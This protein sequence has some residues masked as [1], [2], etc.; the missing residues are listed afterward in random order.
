MF[1]KHLNSVTPKKERWQSFM[2]NITPRSARNLKMK[3]TDDLS[4]K[5]CC[6]DGVGGQ[7]TFYGGCS[8]IHRRSRETEKT[9]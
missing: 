7:A 6:Y 2:N 8:T 1:S 4:D 5:A 9:A 3:Q